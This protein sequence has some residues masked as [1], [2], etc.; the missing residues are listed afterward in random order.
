MTPQAATNGAHKDTLPPL[1]EI[2]EWAALLGNWRFGDANAHY[3][4]RES[5]T[6]YSAPIDAG[7]PVGLALSPLVFRDGSVSCRIQL[8]RTE[9]T[10]GGIAVGVRSASAP[11]VVAA[12]GGFNYAY[13][14]LQHG[15][16]HALNKPAVLL[17]RKQSELPF[18]VRPYRA[19]FYDDPIGGKKHVQLLRQHLKAALQSAT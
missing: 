17:A 4:G 18:D 2:R 16:A 13:C 6:D 8:H 12:I 14:V 3:L 19:I 10:S 9:S 11:Y 15:Y 1:E 5:A 7:V